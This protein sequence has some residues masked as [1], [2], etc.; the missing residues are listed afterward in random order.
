MSFI[1]EINKYYKF[2]KIV[3]YI[4]EALLFIFDIMV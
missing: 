3:K 2:C 4:M 1:K